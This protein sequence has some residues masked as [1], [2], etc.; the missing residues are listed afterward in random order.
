VNGFMQVS[1]SGEP[2]SYLTGKRHVSAN[3]PPKPSGP[4]RCDERQAL[5]HV[6]E[7]GLVPG[8]TRYFVLPV[9]WNDCARNHVPIVIERDRNHRLDIDIGLAAASRSVTLVMVELHRHADHRS[10]WVG[11]LL[12]QVGAVIVP[13]TLSVFLQN[14]GTD[15]LTTN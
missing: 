9:D 12:R 5:R 11:Q 13:A 14:L 4:G 6:A 15:T 1:G 8:F 7:A 10:E 2:D 3:R